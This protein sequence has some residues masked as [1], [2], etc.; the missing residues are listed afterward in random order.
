MSGISKIHNQIPVV[1]DNK[2]EISNKEIGLSFSAVLEQSMNNLNRN[3][4]NAQNKL[5]A[6]VNKIPANYRPMLEAQ[7]LM[8]NC[9]Y[10]I[11]YVTK[12]ADAAQTSIK[13]L[14]QQN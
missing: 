14:Q 3:W 11:E 2:I 9:N 12:L 13:K 4:D 10:Q 6:I 5:P 1:K 7:M 8:S